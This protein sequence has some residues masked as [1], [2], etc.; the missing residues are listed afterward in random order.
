VG[1][2]QLPRFLERFRFKHHIQSTHRIDPATSRRMTSGRYRGSL[3]KSS[4]RD[5]KTLGQDANLAHI[6]GTF[7]GQNLRN[8]ALTANFRQ[9][10][11]P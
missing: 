9:I 2:P 10:G 6:Q 11:L 1:T 7:P 4:R 3:N 8:N 5:A